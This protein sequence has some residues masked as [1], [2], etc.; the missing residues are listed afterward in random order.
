MVEVV[1]VAAGGVGAVNG[2]DLVVGPVEAL[3]ETTEKLGHGEVGLMVGD[4][5][6]GVQNPRFAVR[7]AEGVAGPEVAVDEG[8]EVG[9][10]EEIVKVVGDM[11]EIATG[12]VV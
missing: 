2:V 4:V 8:G 7:T 12:A 9:L 10:R 1:E 3:R 11:G 6:R 5:G